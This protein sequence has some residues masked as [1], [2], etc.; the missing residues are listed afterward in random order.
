[1]VWLICIN[2]VA[3][4]RDA[5]TLLLFPFHPTQLSSRPFSGVASIYQNVLMTAETNTFSGKTVFHSLNFIQAN[6][7]YHCLYLQKE[8]S[9]STEMWLKSILPSFFAQNNFTHTY[10][11]RAH[12]LPYL[13]AHLGLKNNKFSFRLNFGVR[14]FLRLGLNIWL[15]SM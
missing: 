14:A 15:W 2:V 12:S 7:H 1:M 6:V 13:Q 9:F 8:I 3:K 5:I 4:Q 10:P 11:F